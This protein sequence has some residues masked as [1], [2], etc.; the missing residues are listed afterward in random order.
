M[1]QAKRKNKLFSKKIEKIFFSY[2][3]G[4]R[5]FRGANV[6]IAKQKPCFLPWRRPGLDENSV[7]EYITHQ[8]INAQNAMQVFIST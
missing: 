1:Y 6:K 7:R 3:S 8:S 5:F 2:V 4:L